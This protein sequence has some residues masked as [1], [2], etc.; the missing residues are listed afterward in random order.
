MK[1]AIIPEDIKEINLYKDKGDIAFIFGLKGLSCGYKNA[2]DIND[3]EKITKTYPNE[4]F[5]AINKNI[6]NEDLND[7][8]EKLKQLDKLNIKAVLFYDIALLHLRNKLN[9]KLDL[10]WNQ[11]HMVTNY[12]TCNFYYNKNVKYAI[13]AE[14]ITK[15]EIIEINK[16]TNM[17]LMV[18][19]IGYPNMS[20]SYRKLLT[21][22]Y[23]NKDQ[24]KEKE[25]L[26]IYNNNQ[27]Y[28]VWEEPNGTNIINGTLLNGASFINE[29]KEAKISYGII[30]TTFIDENIKES[31]ITYTQDI[32]KN[33]N[34]KSLI[35]LN[36]LI[37]EDTMFFQKKTIYKVK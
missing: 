34:K 15:D 30:N 10:V 11:T 33:N 12:N 6:F 21:N 2:I 17:N 9:L 3:I 1:L 5:I 31:I 27:K 24:K 20:F 13:V 25:T 8:E 28:I 7:L 4:L 19:L 14:E 23:I 35:K 37:G 22:Y 16:K 29:F 32:L 36:T 26:D 18:H